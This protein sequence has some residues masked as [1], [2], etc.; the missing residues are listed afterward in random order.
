MKALARTLFGL[1]GLLALAVPAHA[2]SADPETVALLE[3]LHGVEPAPTP[4]VTEPATEAVSS[5]E[6]LRESKNILATTNL[7]DKPVANTP[8]TGAQHGLEYWQS[9]LEIA[10]NQRRQQRYD[11]AAPTLVDLIL[12]NTP[13]SMKRS[14]MLELAVIEQERNQLTR[15]QQILAHYLNKWPDDE[16]TPEIILRQ[17]L[18]FRQLGMNSLALTKFYSVMTSS[19]VLKSDKLEYYRRLVLQAQTE[20]AETYFQQ[21]KFSDS[22]DFFARLLKQ[23]SPLLN[24]PQI[25][26]KLIRSL[27][28]LGRHEEV[29]KQS[30]DFLG[31]HENS[32]E[33]P[34]V[35]FYLASALKRL[36]RT[37]ESLQ[38]VLVL[39][40]SQHPRARENPEAWAY[41][42]L[43]T[44]NE[45]GNMLYQEG[46]YLSA[47]QVYSTLA[48]L[49]TNAA[50]QLP[51]R[52]Q[53]GLTYER[54][55]Q[56]AKAMGEY[57]QIVDQAS[58]ADTNNAP[59]AQTILE[60]A[61]WRQQYLSSQTNVTAVLREFKSARINPSEPE[62]I[63]P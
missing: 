14:A 6:A 59:A 49:S 50:W 5:D 61:R 35:R 17:G 57:Q 18:I 1:G 36:G 39:L 51:V 16:N 22:A 13:E 44:G 38:Q 48:T 33:Q 7:L 27:S 10:R 63:T 11:E 20:I 41:W 19:L 40:Q 56:P 3:N 28:M 31:R 26:Y 42:R 30:H 62:P 43:R 54:L 29:A 4:A 55:E 45:I 24:K 52:Y 25:H 15:A 53:M 37:Q 46:D 8:A 60:L 58:A 47:L 2:A 12:A 21:G 23:D 32:V 9:Q 34:E